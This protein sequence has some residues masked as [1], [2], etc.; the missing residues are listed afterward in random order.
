[1]KKFK[2]TDLLI[3]IVTAELVGALS[4]LFSGES[5]S[6][7]YNSL[8]KPPI[9]PP[10][11]VFPAA[12][13]I[14]YALMGTACYLIYLSDSD[15]KHTAYKLYIIQLFV[16][17]LWSPVFFGTKS[18]TGAMIIAAVLLQTVILT[19]ISFFKISETAGALLIPYVLWSA[20]A[21]YLSVGFLVLN[22]T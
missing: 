3:F 21:L 11:A 18:F 19:G 10:G 7:Y 8:I 15:G 22:R 13:A 17:F 14:L 1:M 16:N 5:F 4:A 12:W 6:A 9:A 2:L 20:Y